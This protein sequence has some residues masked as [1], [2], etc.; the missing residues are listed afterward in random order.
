MT[1]IEIPVL[2]P[3]NADCTFA[4]TLKPKDDTPAPSTTKRAGGRRGSVADGGKA[5]SSVTTH[6]ILPT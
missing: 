5:S 6:K 4:I 2:N 1:T 3:F